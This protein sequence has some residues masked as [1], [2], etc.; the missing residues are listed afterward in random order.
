MH[1]KMTGKKC[2]ADRTFGKKTAGMLTC[3]YYFLY[4]ISSS[5]FFERTL[6]KYC[7][8]SNMLVFST[9]IW[10]A[11]DLTTIISGFVRLII[12]F[13]HF[14]PLVC[15]FV[16]LVPCSNNTWAQVLPHT[17]HTAPIKSKS[18]T[19]KSNSM[20]YSFDNICAFL[21]ARFLNTK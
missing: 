4:I 14:N 10:L 19:L 15:S 6:S 13:Q 9:C 17:A 5:T 7:A 3:R 1:L 8:V 20:D 18:Y 2:Y 12:F 11:E 21:F 16:L